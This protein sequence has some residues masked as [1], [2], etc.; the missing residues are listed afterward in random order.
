MNPEN[1]VI[2]ALE[3]VNDELNQRFVKKNEIQ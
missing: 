1:V 3:R 2:F